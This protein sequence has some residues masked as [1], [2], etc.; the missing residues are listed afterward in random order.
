MGR[1]GGAGRAVSGPA[2]GDHHLSVVLGPLEPPLSHL[3]V[4]EGDGIL[5]RSGAAR[6]GSEQGTGRSAGNVGVVL[7]QIVGG[8]FGSL[9]PVVSFPQSVAVLF[10]RRV[11][12]SREGSGL[13]PLTGFT[14]TVAVVV[15]EEILSIHA[16]D[17]LPG[18]NVPQHLDAGPVPPRGDK[19]AVR[20]TVMVDVGGSA[21]PDLGAVFPEVLS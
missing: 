1:G 19:F 18:H 17:L 14:L 12:L 8:R 10:L 9:Q 21:K 11:R 13:P 3:F 4:G 15:S 6:R 20:S 5:R 16:G 7:L 2:L